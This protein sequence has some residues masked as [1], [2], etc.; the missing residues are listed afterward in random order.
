MRYVVVL[1]ALFLIVFSIGF[2][3]RS[4]DKPAEDIVGPDEGTTT[5]EHTEASVSPSAP[6]IEYDNVEV[7]QYGGGGLPET[8]GL[9]WRRD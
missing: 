7:I 4:C 9:S 3:V 6:V 8:G 1:L 2:A 5:P